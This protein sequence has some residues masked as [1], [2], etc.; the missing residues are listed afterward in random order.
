MDPTLHEHI[1]DATNADV[2][3]KKL[4]NLFAWK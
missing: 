1:S 2:V 4:E 3:L